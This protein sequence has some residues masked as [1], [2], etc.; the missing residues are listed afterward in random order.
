MSDDNKTAFRNGEDKDPDYTS[1]NSD[2][3][4]SYFLETIAGEIQ[5]NTVDY[6]TE[7]GLISKEITLKQ[8]P[9]AVESFN[10]IDRQILTD[11]FTQGNSGI[12]A[13]ESFQ[14]TEAGVLDILIIIDDSSSMDS[15]KQSLSDNLP[16]LLSNISDTNWQIAVATTSDPCLE[17]MGINNYTLKKTSAGGNQ[18]AIEALFRN[19]IRSAYGTGGRERGIEMAY[20]ALLGE[21]PNGIDTPWVRDQSDKVVLIVTDERNCGS[22][23]GEGCGPSDYRPIDFLNAPHTANTK[24]F[25]LLL[26]DQHMYYGDYPNCVGSGSWESLPQDPA[27]YKYLISQTNGSYDNICFSDYAEVLEDMSQNIQN[28]IHVKFE[29][30][31]EPS[32]IDSVLVDGIPVTYTHNNGIIE[33]TSNIDPSAN[34]VTIDYRHS[35]VNIVDNFDIANSPDESTITVR[36]D[37]N[38]VTEDQYEYNSLTQKLVFN[39]TPPENSNIEVSYRES[40]PL[41]SAFSLSDKPI[42]DN[43]QVYVDGIQYENT[44]II[45]DTELTFDSAPNDGQEITVIYERESDKTRKYL[46]IDVEPNKIET[47]IAKDFSTG[48]EIPI[49][50]DGNANLVFADN[51]IYNGRKVLIEYNLDYD[52]L[53]FKIPLKGKLIS[54]SL[55]ISPTGDNPSACQEDIKVD[56]EFIQFFCADKDFEKLSIRYQEA[57]DYENTFSLDI[58]YTGPLDWFVYVDGKLIEDY[59]LFDT[60]VVILKNQ[61]PVGST[62]RI[63]AYP[64]KSI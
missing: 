46:P 26:E 62:V 18:T 48:E 55:E 52:D 35:P 29:L 49:S 6:N 44:T 20:L 36:M 5:E 7:F 45:N 47:V 56:H 57:I 43:Y 27:D 61:L 3:E 17:S 41:N 28:E 19:T 31:Q 40:T 16:A 53:E 42:E 1:N 54:S 50:I 63:E 13:S 2:L 9:L 23:N 24:V 39:S 58:D 8:K 21:C 51:E 37:G 64:S 59:H 60:T 15:Y 30:N 11:N 14:A 25:G 32:A 4:V 10:Q 34:T 33:I 38:L 12:Q 22:S